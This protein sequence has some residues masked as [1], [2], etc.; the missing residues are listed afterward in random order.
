MPYILVDI[1]MVG[2]AASAFVAALAEGSA[3][4]YRSYL[5]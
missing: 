1:I 3:V 2:F 4:F 5:E